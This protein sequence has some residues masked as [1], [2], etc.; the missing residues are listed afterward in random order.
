VHFSG[1]HIAD[2]IGGLGKEEGDMRI[3]FLV[4]DQDLKFPESSWTEILNCFREASSILGT[5]LQ[6]WGATKKLSDPQLKALRGDV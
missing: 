2:S 1:S 4:S 6:G 3:Q 5:H